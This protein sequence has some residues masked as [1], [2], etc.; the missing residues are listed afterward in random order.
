MTAG[1]RLATV[2]LLAW[3][4]FMLVLHFAVPSLEVTWSYAHLWRDPRLVV[5]AL[6]LVA[7]L[8]PATAW[9]W[10]RPAARTPLRPLPRWAL[11][12][13]VGLG[14]VLVPLTLRHAAQSISLDQWWVHE[15]IRDPAANQ[16][17]RWHLIVWTL[18]VLCTPWQ[19]LVW[20]ATA[21]RGLNTFLA[22]LGLL[23]LAATARRLAT[24]RGEAIA[25]TALVWS[26][27][28]VCQLLIAYLDVYPAALLI[29]SIYLWTSCRALDGG[30]RVTW[31]IAIAMISPFFY[32]GLVLLAPSA[33]LL[34]LT[35]LRTRSGRRD[36]VAG[37]ALGVLAAGAATVPGFG[38][39]FAWS[40]YAAALINVSAAPGGY[41]D[42][43]TLLPASFLFSLPHLLDLAHLVILIDGVGLVL[44]VLFGW[45]A[46]FSRSHP[47]AGRLHALFLL[48]VAVPYF[49]YFATMD[50]LWGAFVDWDCFS[51]G[52]S[53]PTLLG[54]YGFVVWG[55]RRPRAFA[56]LLGVAL[57][58]SG[59]HLLA[60]LNAL[61]VDLNVHL[62]ES[63]PRVG[64]GG[65][66]LQPPTP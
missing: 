9:A 52:V 49:A 37:M 59:V 62:L 38:R 34:A 61:H 48:T 51:F 2:A 30:G 63:P 12:A 54:A 10:A 50:E 21:V 6:W 22:W 20:L 66:L 43:S 56:W 35:A 33:A 55:R 16:N 36:L 28:G 26:A 15:C 64:P 42:S 58:T 31:P 65:R 11:M 7:L 32:V 47:P 8:P 19:G 44:L 39:P 23:A 45:W 1:E 25:I 5:A 24:T 13:S 57:A 46:L 40:A 29:Q 14:I 27:L 41:S 3:C 17:A 18:H 4:G 60:R 53:A